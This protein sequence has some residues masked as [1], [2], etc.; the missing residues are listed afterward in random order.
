MINL[1]FKTIEEIKQL[2]ETEQCSVEEILDYFIDRFKKVDPELGSALEV[3]D[4]ESILEQVK[5]QRCFT[6]YS[7]FN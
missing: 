6:W 4:R 2:I 3:F 1:A 5:V 7:R